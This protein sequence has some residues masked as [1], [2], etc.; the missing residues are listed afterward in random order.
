MLGRAAA[1]AVSAR[2]R[3]AITQVASVSCRA[4]NSDLPSMAACGVTRRAAT[5]SVA[6][7]AVSVVRRRLCPGVRPYLG[8]AGDAAEPHRTGGLAVCGMTRSACFFRCTRRARRRTLRAR[9]EPHPHPCPPV[10]WAFKAVRTCSSERRLFAPLQERRLQPVIATSRGIHDGGNERWE[11]QRRA[12]STR[13]QKQELRRRWKQVKS[14]AGMGFARGSVSP[15]AHDAPVAANRRDLATFDG[16]A[17]TGAIFSVSRGRRPA[18][19][20]RSA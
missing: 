11:V 3:A 13:E 7:Q 1:A 6:G 10:R 5:T 12:A 15:S 9:R 20:A 8:E 19:A 2:L 4:E 16:Y 14:A 18:A 17:R